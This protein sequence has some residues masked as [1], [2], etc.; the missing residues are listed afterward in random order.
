MLAPH[1][2]AD[3]LSDLSVRVD[4]VKVQVGSVPLADYPG[5]LRPTGIVEIHGSG[6]SG[7]GENVAFDLKAQQTFRQRATALVPAGT[8]RLSALLNGNVDP[9]ERTALEAALLDLALRQR[10]SSMAELAGVS[11]SRL[12]WLSS[13]AATADP[14]ARVRAIRTTLDVSEFKVDV[15]AGWTDS[16]IDELRAAGEI[17]TL[18]FKS[19]GD[20]DSCRRLEA[21]FP[22]S[23]FEDPP[24]AC[25]ASLVALDR[26]ISDHEAVVRAVASGRIVNLKA[27]RMGGFL[28][29]M[30]GLEAIRSARGRA[31]FGGMFEVGPGREQARQVAALY[32]PTEPNDLGPLLGGVSSM[33]GRS[34]SEMA[35]HHPGFGSGCDWARSPTFG[36]G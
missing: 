35:V 16:V 6:V 25:A 15:D 10:Q 32:C 18:D 26:E 34:P 27:P 19:A 23:I 24:A 3:A 22:T 30:R 36:G 2:L 21:A 20:P 5:G 8:W 31:Y 17:V 29:V 1:A 12:R 14:A 11:D 9:F 13:F 28:E 7:F 4:G 33:R